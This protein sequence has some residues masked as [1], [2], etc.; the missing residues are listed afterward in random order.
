[1]KSEFKTLVFL[2]L[3]FSCKS[4]EKLSE[5]ELLK[6]SELNETAVFINYVTCP[7]K[8]GPLDKLVFLRQ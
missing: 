8:I 3:I 7:P 2:L 6:Y 4:N 5:D 1:M